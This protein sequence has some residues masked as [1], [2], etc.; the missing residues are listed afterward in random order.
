MVCVDYL[1]LEKSKG[2]WENVLVIADHFTRCAQAIP[3]RNQTA[4]TTAKKLF[5][6]YTV[7]YGFPS[8]LHSDQGRNFESKV[9]QE[10][11]KIAGEKSRPT[12]YHPMGNGMTERFNRTLLGMLGNLPDLQYMHTIQRSTS[13]PAFLLST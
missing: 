6:K 7:H 8:R 2:G 4:L 11:C 13:L 1:K 12:P 9:I 5:D 10:L 3:T